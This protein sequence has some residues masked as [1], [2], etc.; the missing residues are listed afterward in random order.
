[1]ADGEAVLDRAKFHAMTE[2]TA[3]DW[4]PSAGPRR[5]TGASSP[6]GCWRT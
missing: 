3:E 1:M 5:R 2:G 6:T 4:A